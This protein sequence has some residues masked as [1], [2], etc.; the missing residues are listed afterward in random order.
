MGKIYEKHLLEL[1]VNHHIF[2]INLDGYN[3]ITEAYNY[4]KSA[5]HVIIATPTPTHAFCYEQIRFF[6]A[7]IPILIEKP[8][9]DNKNDLYI[10]EDKNV[11]C[12]MNERCNKALLWARDNWDLKSVLSVL[13]TR[14][15]V[16]PDF[17][18]NDMLIHDI[19]I[20]NLFFKN[21]AIKVDYCHNKIK[22]DSTLEFWSRDGYHLIN[23][24]KQEVFLESKMLFS[25]P[26]PFTIKDQLRNFLDGKTSNALLA[27]KQLL[28]SNKFD[29]QTKRI[30][31]YI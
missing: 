19:D 14:N 4:L 17:T 12:G 2:D 15:T 31:C 6:K 24:V 18:L 5:S 13:I 28:L 29:V 1:N 22:L 23:L 9:V 16:N 25:N 26:E 20:K 11:F 10:L 7:V 21:A 30:S 8:V 27:H 3:D